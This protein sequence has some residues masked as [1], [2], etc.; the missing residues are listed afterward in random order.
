M[1]VVAESTSSPSLS[2]TNLTS[3]LSPVAC[4]FT[5]TVFCS[6]VDLSLAFE[7]VVVALA[8]GVGF[9]SLIGIV[10]VSEVEP[11]SVEVPEPVEVEPVPVV[12]VFGEVLVEESLPDPPPRSPPRPP[13]PMALPRS[14]LPISMAPS[15]IS[16]PA[17]FKYSSASVVLFVLTFSCADACGAKC[18]ALNGNASAIAPV[19]IFFV[20]EFIFIILFRQFVV[21]YY[22]N[23]P[24]M[25]TFIFK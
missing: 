19:T 7:G 15:G 6:L 3:S 4:T 8:S 16:I 17:T 1:S 18:A 5:V 25:H 13:P 2:N 21:Y 23:T 10:P 22:Y 24:C 9:V 14:S 12:S 20:V 11:V